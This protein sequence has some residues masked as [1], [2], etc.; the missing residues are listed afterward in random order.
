MSEEPTL[1]T[2]E[3]LPLR[4]TRDGWYILG[5]PWQAVPEYNYKNACIGMGENEIE[6][7]LNRN[8]SVVRGKA[9]YPEFSLDRHVARQPLVFDPSRPLHAGWDWL[10]C[11]AFVPSQL[12]SFGQWLI[13]PSLSPPESES[14]GIY[15]FAEQVA[16]HLL[17]R[18][19]APH[20]LTL[21][22]LEIVHVGD[23]S[24]RNPPAKTGGRK[25]ETA[26]AFDILNRG[27]KMY[28]GE[29]DRGDPVFEQK[30]GWKWRVIPGAMRISD[31]IEAV[32]ARLRVS[33][34]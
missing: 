3:H 26:S 15:E 19:A 29:D 18:Y 2:Y 25:Q 6:M 17:R 33:H 34:L 16:N 14:I 30:P 27:S 20:G 22:D 8:W 21:D 4:H 13:F 24:G 10:G 11:P 31:R 7:E 32:R 23:P 12:N 28:L 5:V 1:P 9:V